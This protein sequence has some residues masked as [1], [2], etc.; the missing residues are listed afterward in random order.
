MPAQELEQAGRP[1]EGTEEV[2]APTSPEVNFA[3]IMCDRLNISNE[4]GM[5][6]NEMFITMG[7]QC[8]ISKIAES[9]DSTLWILLWLGEKQLR[10][11]KVVNFVNEPRE[12]K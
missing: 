2:S 3:L 7:H 4:M 1:G 12:G 10:E 5:F 9:R 6:G 8:L 11:W